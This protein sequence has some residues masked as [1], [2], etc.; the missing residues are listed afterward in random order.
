MK[1]SVISEGQPMF[2]KELQLDSSDIS[3]NETLEKYVPGANLS[4]IINA[5]LDKITAGEE[6]YSIKNLIKDIAEEHEEKINERR[7]GVIKL[8]E[9]EEMADRLGMTAKTLLKRGLGKSYN[10]EELYRAHQ[11]L[12]TSA[13]RLKKKHKQLIE[14][15]KSNITEAEIAEFRV[16]MQEHAAIQ[17][18]FAGVR[19]EAGRALSS[20]RIIAQS[21]GE[22]NYDKVL[23]ALG[24]KDLNEKIIDRILEMDPENEVA[25]NKFVE[26]MSKPTTWDMVYEYWIN[27]ILSAPT[28]HIV[29]ITSN[30]L[31]SLTKPLLEM[32]VSAIINMPSI[33]KGNNR[34]FYLG[35]IPSHFVGMYD[36]LFEGIK[37]AGKSFKT[38]IPQFGKGSKLESLKFKSI[39]GVAGGVIRTPGRALMAADEFFKWIIYRSQLASDAYKIA[40]NEGLKGEKLAE[41]YSELKLSPSEK[42]VKKAAF[43]AE[44]RTFTNPLGEFGNRVMRL[45]SDFVADNKKYP[46]PLKFVL[47]FIRTPTN[48]AKFALERT[49]A[50][51]I[52]KT[53]KIL[54]KKIPP[55]EIAEELAKPIVGSIIIAGALILSRMGLITGAGPK[56]DDERDTLYRMGWLP[57]SLKIGDRYYSYSRLEPLGSVLGM[58]ADYGDLNKN[59]SELNEIAERMA[60][61]VGKNIISKTYMKGLSD[62]VDALSDP[63]RYGERYLQSMAGSLIPNIIAS[64]TRASDKEMKEIKNLADTFKSRLPGLDDSLYPKRDLWG[65]P[66]ERSGNFWIKFLSPIQYSA[67]KGNELDKEILKVGAN[68]D[69][70]YKKI[71]LS[72]EQKRITKIEEN[73]LNIPPDI[74]DNYQKLAGKL[75]KYYA[76]Q[77][78]ASEEY[79]TASDETKKDLIE[80]SIKNGRNMLIDNIKNKVISNYIKNNKMLL[81]QRFNKA[82]K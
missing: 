26:A 80:N 40:K 69:T 23:D 35:Q 49:P 5:G 71:K 12:T 33:L 66:I 55:E 6:A 70:P 10:A 28:T 48:I 79:K 72:E 76:L 1:E 41:R 54:N 51:F 57:Y 77:T 65:N 50:G 61:S 56:D 75:A 31:T 36:G 30:L 4:K 7:R 20:L 81:A 22:K 19:A 25:I 43:E 37:M 8:K 47:P 68:V 60:Y 38:E 18:E 34:N 67:A 53:Y 15:G 21:L 39:P 17:A 42:M 58:T 63:K 45:R 82:G 32:P 62:L 74:F 13:E 59:E 24:G 29:N 52:S 11:I 16:S 27:S 9:T 73:Y 14:K 2:A 46:N 3:K 64:G 44:Y 78:I